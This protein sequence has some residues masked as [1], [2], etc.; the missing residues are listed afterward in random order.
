MKLAVTVCPLKLDNPS[1]GR[2]VSWGCR[3][4]VL[5]GTTT[6]TVRRT[7]YILSTGRSLCLCG[8]SLLLPSL[9]RHQTTD[10][11]TS[12]TAFKRTDCLEGGA[13]SA[14]R[15]TSNNSF[16]L[17]F[18]ATCWMWAKYSPPFSITG[19][20]WNICVFSF[21][22]HHYIHNLSKRLTLSVFHL[23]L[24]HHTMFCV[25]FVFHWICLLREIK[26]LTVRRV[27]QNSKAV[28]CKIKTKRSKTLNSQ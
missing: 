13:A 5:I 4:F 27:N 26:Y 12:A 24:G 16:E 11:N 15:M 2:S 20:Y 7:F 18:L 25:F 1:A 19:L 9:T 23:V 8:G 14:Q 3:L 17:V 10:Q 28:G 22:W 21:Q 6:Q